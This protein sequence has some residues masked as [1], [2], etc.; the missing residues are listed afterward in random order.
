[1]ARAKRTDRTEARRRYRAEL[2]GA[3]PADIETKTA[4]PVKDSAPV[5][6]PGARPSIMAAFRGAVRPLDVRGDIR[7]LPVI[8]R[9]RGVLISIGV[10]VLATAVFVIATNELGASLD[11]T[12][13][14]PLKDKTM[15]AATSIS[16]LAISLFVAPPP[17]A[18][19]FLI[20]FFAKRAS[21]LTGLIFGV[22]AA[23]CYSILIMSP[24]GRLLTGQNSA[25]PFVLQAWVAGPIGAALF[26]SA[27]AWYRRFLDLANPGRGQ[28]RPARQTQS[29]GA[30]KRR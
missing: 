2:A 19:G 14:E 17:A 25:D 20:G 13:A 12:L 6:V 28:R 7:A 3:A 22:V 16:Y 1:L 5:A 10:A 9:E 24:A 11:F 21:W 23:T 29:K 15:P 18:G 30:P 27:A 8:I 26:A 4:V